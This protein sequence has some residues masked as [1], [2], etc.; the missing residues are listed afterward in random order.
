[1]KN[2]HLVAPLSPKGNM[3]IIEDVL[4]LK[5]MEYTTVSKDEAKYDSTKCV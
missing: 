4:R 1:M 2:F 5:K 3:Y